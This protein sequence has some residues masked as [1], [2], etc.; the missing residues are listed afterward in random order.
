[1]DTIWSAPLK[2]V[3]GPKYELVAEKIRKRIASGVLV[4]GAKLPPVRELAYRL[5]ITPGTVARAYGVLTDEGLLQGEVGRGTFVAHPPP[6][7]DPEYIAAGPLE[8][9]VIAHGTGL[10]DNDDVN[11]FSP[12]LPSVGQARLI[13]ELLARVAEDPPSGLM[14]YPSRANSRPAREAVA[15]WLADA[16]IG[17]VGADDI[18]LTNGGQNGISLVLQATLRGRRPAILVEDL[19]YP[20]FRRAAELLRAD[21]IPVA[22][23][24]EGLIP[25]AVEAAARGCDAQ[26]LCTSPE[27]HNPT[28]ITTPLHRRKALAEV[29]RKLDLQIL[30]DDCYQMRR[31]VTPSYRVL[32]PERAWY[33]ASLS[34]SLTPALRVGFGV[35]PEGA[36][37]ALRRAAEHGF[38]GLATPMTDLTEMLLS[39]PRVQGL[40]DHVA[41]VVG[42]YV[43]SAVNILGR[44]DLKWR[45]EAAFLWL[46]LPQGWR[47]GA[48]CRAAEAR[49][50]Q[51]RSAED[52][53]PRNANTPH[54]VRFAVN[55]GIPLTRF[56][57]AL[58]RL[59]DLLD[60]PP[61]RIEV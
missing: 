31:A 22:M 3:K 10:F 57:D 45:E 29:A 33:V 27:I 43:Q 54:A 11:L 14:H 8:V 51:L 40:A 53:A 48:F 60:N 56:E 37:A 18:V 35:A 34:K 20:G 4:P 24:G 26:V 16:P 9:D 6:E 12:H 47:A 32:A 28:L 5:G 15:R 36:A 49:G 58:H 25:E 7:P 59:R 19:S 30:E 44:Y 1:M 41:G 61:E 13:R 52:F 42:R 38:F 39:D 46:E 17:T 23:D 55:A 2:N 21:V 50:V